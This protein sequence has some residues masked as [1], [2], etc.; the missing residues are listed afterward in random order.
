MIITSLH[1]LIILL[2]F[3]NHRITVAYGIIVVNFTRVKASIKILNVPLMVYSSY[4]CSKIQ[5]FNK[6]NVGDN[7]EQKNTRTLDH[8]LEVKRNWRVSVKLKRSI[9]VNSFRILHFI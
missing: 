6:F 9:T 1:V 5:G 2:L 3:F 7:G 8:K 4:R